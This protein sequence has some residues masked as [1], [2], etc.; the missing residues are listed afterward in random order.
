MCSIVKP[1]E[2]AAQESKRRVITVT[3]Q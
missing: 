3:K 2:R 1:M